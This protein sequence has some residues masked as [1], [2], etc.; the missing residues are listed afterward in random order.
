[1][2]FDRRT[3]LAAGLGLGAAGAAG[4][5]LAAE[6]RAGAKAKNAGRKAPPEMSAQEAGQ[7]EDTP[8]KPDALRADALKPDAPGDQTALLQALIDKAATRERAVILPEGTFRVSDLRLRA[9]TCL[10]GQS[11]R[12]VLMFAGGDAFITADRADGLHVRGLTLDGAYKPINTDRGDGLFSVS[13]AK[14][15]T[16]QDLI[17]RNGAQ[18]GVSLTAC[19]GRVE[20]CAI[21]DVLEFAI[22]TLDGEGLE[23]RANRITR[24][25]N[26]GILVWRTKKGS[27][28]TIVSSN[29]ISQIRNSAGGTGEYGNGINVFRAGGVLVEGNRITDCSYSAVRG[30]AADNIQI[31]ANSCERLGE[32]AIYSEFGFEGSLIANNLIDTAACGISV[33]NFNEGGRLAVVQG[34]LIRNLFRREKEPEGE[35]RGEGIG[36][37]A[38]ASITGN[39]IEG[40]PTVGIQIGWGAY[41]RDVAATGN[42][43]RNARIGVSITNASEA[44]ACLIANN[45]ISRSQ[46]GAIRAM[47]HGSPLGPDLARDPPK[48][49]RITVLGNV[50]T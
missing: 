3:L 6:P 42:V 29:R 35:R 34:N 5:T 24:C 7:A 2:T 4:P 39:T 45:L 41:M 16:L 32:V 8:T 11:H 49:G 20:S 25:A 46:D 31:I 23:I 33:T 28:G 27:D 18:G 43:V 21:A 38:D 12:S 26:N 1:M 15:V 50:A 30:N 37:E 40:A 14:D 47:N 9:G 48:G 22:K 17:V 36:V 44:G 19:S 10:L 13:N